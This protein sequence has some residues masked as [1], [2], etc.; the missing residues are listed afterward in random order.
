MELETRLML[1]TKKPRSDQSNAK[2]EVS[3]VF[4]AQ[5]ATVVNSHQLGQ[6]Q[7]RNSCHGNRKTMRNISQKWVIKCQTQQQKRRHSNCD[8]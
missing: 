8:D 1:E 3:E 7:G 4:I 6:C 2:P 5:V